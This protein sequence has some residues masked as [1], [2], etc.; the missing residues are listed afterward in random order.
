MTISAYKDLKLKLMEMR[1]NYLDGNISHYDLFDVLDMI[2]ESDNI[3]DSI[4][5]F[6]KEEE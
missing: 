6:M 5:D 1:E 3:Y 4:M 2:V